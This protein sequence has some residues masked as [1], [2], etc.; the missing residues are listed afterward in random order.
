MLVFKHTITDSIYQSRQITTANFNKNLSSYEY[1]LR[2][3]IQKVSRET[4][5]RRSEIGIS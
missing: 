3:K 2:S 1:Q 4:K 5:S